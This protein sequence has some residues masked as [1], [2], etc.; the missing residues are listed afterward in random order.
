[1]IGAQPSNPFFFSLRRRSP[2]V[3][4]AGVQWRNLGSLQ[5]LPPGFKQ[6]SCLSLLSS[7]DYRRK[8]PCLAKPNFYSTTLQDIKLLSM[9]CDGYSVSVKLTCKKAVGRY[10]RLHFGVIQI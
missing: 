2:L 4:L 10:A 7:W 1:V 5:P 3:A 8:P 9:G 6:F